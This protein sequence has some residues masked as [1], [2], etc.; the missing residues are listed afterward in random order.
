[1]IQVIQQSCTWQQWHIIFCSQ[2]TR[3]MLETK[4]SHLLTGW[5]DKGNAFLFADPGKLGVFTQ[6]SVARMNGLG[7]ILLRY[8]KNLFMI[9]ITLGGRCGT[10]AYSLISLGYM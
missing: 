9:K 7:T 4:V 6:E 2:G 1:M 5:P 3:G 10:Y 8:P